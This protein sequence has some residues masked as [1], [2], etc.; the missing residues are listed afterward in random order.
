MTRNPE[1]K[2]K[3]DRLT[4]VPTSLED[5]KKSSDL[6]RLAIQD[7][8]SIHDLLVESLDLLFRVHHWPPGNPQLTLE[9]S[10]LPGKQLT[11]H[12]GCGRVGV[13]VGVHVS[14]GKGRV[15]CLRCF[16]EVPLRHDVKVWNWKKVS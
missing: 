15:C 9:T 5:M 6:K 14:S 1:T 7:G 4:F 11:P 13:Y 10:L 3:T 8:C 12:C 16:G 2:T